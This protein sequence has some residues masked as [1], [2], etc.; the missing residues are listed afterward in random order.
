VPRG[1]DTGSTY[2]PGTVGGLVGVLGISFAWSGG[3][4]GTPASSGPRCVVHPYSRYPDSRSSRA[5]ISL[6]VRFPAASH[7]TAPKT[8][9][10]AFSRCPVSP[11]T[12]AATSCEIA[13]KGT[14]SGT[15]TTAKPRSL[16]AARKASVSGGTNSC[17]DSARQATPASSRRSR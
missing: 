14:A 3:G 17:S 7:W 10:C 11:C 1:P 4:T 6:V 8:G 13:M 15:S 9:N 16:A 2:P 12:A 5:K